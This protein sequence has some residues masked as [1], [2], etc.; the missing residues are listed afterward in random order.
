MIF[1]INRGSVV[2]SEGTSEGD[3]ESLPPSSNSKPIRYRDRCRRINTTK[4][5]K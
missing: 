2:F 1:G 5:A 3:I 4:T